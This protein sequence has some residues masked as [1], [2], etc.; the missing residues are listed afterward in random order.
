[1]QVI[2][3]ER[4]IKIFE[5]YTLATLP[6]TCL[7]IGDKGCGKRTLAMKIADD[8][9]F[10][11]VL[12]DSK[13]TPEEIIDY[14]QKPVYTLFFIDLMLFTEKQQNQFLKFIEEPGQYNYIILSTT[15]TAGIL[16]TIVNRC[17]RFTF[18]PYTQEQLKFFDWLN[19]VEDPIAY[20]ICKTPG[21][22]TDINMKN[23]RPLYDLCKTIV[24]SMRIVP[25]A[26]LMK[27][28]T[29]INYKEDYDKFT[30]RYFFKMLNFVALD[31]FKTNNNQDA[32]IVYLETLKA[33]RDFAEAR[34]LNKESYVY[35]FLNRLWEATH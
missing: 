14:M 1:M 6:K 27:V 10:Q 20:C 15:S 17:V 28:A 22:I 13:I 18:D 8:F 16:P 31:E 2:G 33:E 26:N 35:S 23:V 24:N 25:Y 7:F 5:N 29:K 9:H 34:S 4:L 19:P 11:L 32:F 12:V 21:E 30:F 3:Q